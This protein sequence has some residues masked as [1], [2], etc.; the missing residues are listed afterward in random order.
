MNIEKI[1]EKYDI[2]I[3][4]MDLIISDFHK[5]MTLTDIVVKNNG[6]DF[7][8]IYAICSFHCKDE[9]ECSVEEF[10][11]EFAVERLEYMKKSVEMYQNIKLRLKIKKKVKSIYDDFQEYLKEQGK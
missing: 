4:E 1:L 5:R 7:K 6:M 8:K 3:S 9:L 2:S 11:P 10:Y